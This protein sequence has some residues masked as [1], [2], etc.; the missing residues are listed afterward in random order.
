FLSYV[1]PSYEYYYDATYL[2]GI[3]LMNICSILD[4]AKE[5]YRHII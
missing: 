1:S 2:N 4:T 5:K 3:A